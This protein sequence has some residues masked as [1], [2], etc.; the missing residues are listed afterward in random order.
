MFFFTCCT[1]IRV[2]GCPDTDCWMGIGDT[3]LRKTM[4]LWCRA[5]GLCS[6]LALSGVWGAAKPFTGLEPEI[7]PRF[8]RVKL[9]MAGLGLWRRCACW[10]VC[11]EAAAAAAGL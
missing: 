11:G 4:P 9:R 1:L 6:V 10:V 5:S 3:G 2:T 8:C 7:R